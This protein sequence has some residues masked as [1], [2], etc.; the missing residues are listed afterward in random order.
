MKKANN[1]K[2]QKSDVENETRDPMGVFEDVIAEAGGIP[3]LARAIS[4]STT[5]IK[6]WQKNGAIPMNRAL[7]IG[8]L[9]DLPWT[10][11]VSDEDAM[12]IS[13]M[14]LE[15]SLGELHA[16]LEKTLTNTTAVLTRMFELRGDVLGSI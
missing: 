15:R 14:Q 16:D 3:E 9:F 4:V 13:L 8:I 10:A 7:V 11:L 6:R 1:L 12:W 5:E 2:T